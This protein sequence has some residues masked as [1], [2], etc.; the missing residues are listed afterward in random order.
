MDQILSIVLAFL[1]CLN[2]LI[3]IDEIYDYVLNYK[4]TMLRHVFYKDIDNIKLIQVINNNII[5]KW[6]DYEITFYR[7]DNY[8]IFA[9][10]KTIVFA[11]RSKYGLKLNDQICNSII[12]KFEYEINNE[13][14]DINNYIISLK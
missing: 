6:R 5:L 12:K 4:S 11:P 1:L 14:I 2:T 13:A 9:F 8:L 7:K 10:G 3:Y